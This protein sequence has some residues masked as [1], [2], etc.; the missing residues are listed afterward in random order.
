MLL[1]VLVDH[2]LLVLANL[3][4]VQVVGNNR[5]MD[6]P[7]QQGVCS[8]IYTSPAT[9]EKIRSWVDSSPASLH[10][11]QFEAAS[12]PCGQPS[13]ETRAARSLSEASNRH[14]Q[15]HAVRTAQPHEN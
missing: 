2:L 11:K 12:A 5:Q 8:P 6:S 4:T 1:H 3:D 13:G 10:V 15:A 14:L 9:Q 7:V